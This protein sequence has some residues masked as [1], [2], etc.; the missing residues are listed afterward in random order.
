M[1][2]LSNPT[3]G[4]PEIQSVI[5]VLK[6]LHLERGDVTKKLEETLQNYFK[7]KHAII[8]TNGTA[9]LFVG[10]LACNIGP[11][12]EVITT[13]LSFIATAN[14]ILLSGAKPVFVDVDNDTFNIDVSK[15]EEKIT[16]KTKAILTVDL[17]GYP[18]EYDQLRKLAD[19]YK[20]YL[21]SDS[22]QAIGSK[23]KG[24]DINNYTDVTVFSFFGS[25][26]IASG[27]GG[28]L[29]T[30][31]ES[32]IDKANLLISHGQKRGEKYNYLCPGWNFRPTDMQSALISTQLNRLEDINNKRRK[33]AEY[34][35]RHLS[36]ID[37]LVLPQIKP[38]ITHTFSRY[39]IKVLNDFPLSR[40]ELKDYLFMNNIETEIAYPTPL[41]DYDYLNQY[42]IGHF[43]IVESAVNQILSLPIHQNLTKDNLDY[44]IKIIKKAAL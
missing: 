37:G 10:L 42:K 33:N 3:I 22:C 8:T 18:A 17:Y 40:N 35:Q 26:N 15:I 7:S 44:L 39:T 12:D 41:F 34:L 21:I 1:I 11:E 29:L 43:P 27:E 32:I 20:L 25:K 16:S 28:A 9:A 13:P 19:K 38:H 4:E 31:D 14:V 24:K 5:D 30:N 36:I 6:S 23:Y 2:K